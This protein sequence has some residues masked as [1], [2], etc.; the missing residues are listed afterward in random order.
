MRLISCHDGRLLTHASARLGETRE[1]GFGSGLPALDDVAPGGVFARGAVHELL[2]KESHGKPLFLAALLAR[3]AAGSGAVIWCDPN[4]ELYPP[5]MASHG[6]P[7]KQLLLLRCSA[8]A[9][10]WA[11]TECLRCK[12]TSVVIAAVGRLSRI[13]ARRL[14]LAAETGGGVGILLRPAGP[15]SQVYAAAT[16]WLIKPAPGQ[17]TVQRWTVQ[18]LHGHGGR[19]DQSVTLECCRENHLVRAIASMA[20]RPDQKK[21]IVARAS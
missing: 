20:D 1:Q 14:Q 4:R 7:L 21:P 10:I 8:A 16:R 11:I 18:L 15:I 9:Q 2:A 6:I 19:L 5:A 13:Q 17:R 12:G 3:A